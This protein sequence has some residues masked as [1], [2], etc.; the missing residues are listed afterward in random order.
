MDD[1]VAQRGP[2]RRARIL[3]HKDLHNPLTYVEAC[4]LDELELMV[5]I[6]A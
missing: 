1:G 3:G 6:A 5:T 4:G 2:Q